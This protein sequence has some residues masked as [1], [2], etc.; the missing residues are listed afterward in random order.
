MSPQPRSQIRCREIRESDFDAVAELLSRSFSKREF[1]LLRLRRLAERDV[2][3]GL[4]RFG[5]LLACA[6]AVVGVILMISS[7][8]VR[9][10]IA[11]VR[12]NLSSWHVE[13]E[14]R[15]YA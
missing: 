14:Y 5:Y 15:G 4:P 11:F 10:G 12:C 13:P 7:T 8:I 9:N 1:Q 3:P 2:P 6:D